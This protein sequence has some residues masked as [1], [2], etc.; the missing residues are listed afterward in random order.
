M[1]REPKNTKNS[2]YAAI[3]DCGINVLDQININHV[4]RF[5]RPLPNILI[6]IKWA[7]MNYVM[8]YSTML[9]IHCMV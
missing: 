2:D 9:C 6:I 7:S 3:W 1:K 4:V 8:L 5:R